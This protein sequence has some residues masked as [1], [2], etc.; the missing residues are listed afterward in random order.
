M[1]YGNIRPVGFEYPCVSKLSWNTIGPSQH[2]FALHVCL[3]SLI[4]RNDIN[5]CHNISL[6]LP[7]I[8]PERC[9][10]FAPWRVTF[11]CRM[12]AKRDNCSFVSNIRVW[13][14]L[15]GGSPRSVYVVKVTPMAYRDIDQAVSGQPYRGSPV[16]IPCQ[17]ELG[18]VVNRETVGQVLLRLIGFLL[19]AIIPPLL[20]VLHLLQ[21]PIIGEVPSGLVSPRPRFKSNISTTPPPI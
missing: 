10:S 19:S 4:L 12:K 8:C 7:L 3:S 21:K 20:C 1:P 14:G 9:H 18:Y 2:S 15:L 16:S 13:T 6:P 11:H 5:R 17:P